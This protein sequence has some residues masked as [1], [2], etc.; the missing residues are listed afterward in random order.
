M[1]SHAAHFFSEIDQL[2]AKL[3]INVGIMADWQRAEKE[4][5]Q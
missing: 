5:N 1:E 2:R 3:L 4:I